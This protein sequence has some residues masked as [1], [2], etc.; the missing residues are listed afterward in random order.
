MAK[1][2]LT[3]IVL[4]TVIGRA[5][6]KERVGSVKTFNQGRIGYVVDVEPCRRRC[7]MESS[8]S[9]RKKLKLGRFMADI[10]NVGFGILLLYP[11]CNNIVE[12]NSALNIGNVAGPPEALCP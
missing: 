6:I 1:Q 9:T 2:I 3:V 12:A 5:E 8:S 11:L 7:A 10:G 4:A